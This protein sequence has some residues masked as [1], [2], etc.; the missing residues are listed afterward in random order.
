MATIAWP[1]SPFLVPQVV[2]WGETRKIRGSGSPV[3]SG[4]E[5]TS[6][7][8]YTHRW[9]ADITL[10]AHS[11]FAVRAAQEAWLS[12]LRNGANRTT[13]H[14]FQHPLPYGTM[15]GNPTIVGTYPAGSN[16]VI[17]AATTGETVLAGDMIGITTTASY[18]VQLVRVVVGGT[19]ASGTV[20]LT[21]EPALR[22]STSTGQ[23]VVWN[24][25]A[26][27]WRLMD[28]EWKQTSSAKSASAITVSFLEVLRE[29]N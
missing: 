21:F 29:V 13:F 19:V 27:L 18:A 7:I 22:A 6:E 23:S 4:D 11:S 24:K 16:T 28:T 20:T 26:A 9:M 15:R 8:P 1:T 3:L 2:A 5:Q 17:V 14:H 10:P 25:P 12:R